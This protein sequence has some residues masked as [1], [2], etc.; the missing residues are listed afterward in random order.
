MNSI[1][2]RRVIPVAF[3]ALAGLSIVGAVASPANAA[4]IQSSGVV[5][6][7]AC[8]EFIVPVRPGSVVKVV[9]YTHCGSG[10][11]RVKAIID[12]GSDS[13]CVTV[14][15]NQTRSLVEYVSPIQSFNRIVRC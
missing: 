11:V 6:A 5:A 14:G 1:V 12:R 15:S 3:G 9:R 7:A 4:D 10:S 13:D 2:A 8:G